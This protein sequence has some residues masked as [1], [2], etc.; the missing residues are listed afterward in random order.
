M[1]NTRRYRTPAGR[2]LTDADIDGISDEVARADYDG[3]FVCA[4]GLRNYVATQF[5]AEK[6]G[7][8]GLDLL[9][10]FVRWDGQHAE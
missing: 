8:I 3:E 7:R 6:S 4:L 10:R 2:E 1:N 9:A 5:H